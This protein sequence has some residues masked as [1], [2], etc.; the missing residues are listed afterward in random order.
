[1]IENDQVRL[2]CLI[3]SNP[4]CSQI[5]WLFNQDELS[6]RTCSN[7]YSEEYLIENIT[8]LQSGL[9]TCEVWN[10]LNEHIQGIS[11]SSVEVRVQC[12]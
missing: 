4:K 3:D 6:K 12:K 7:F 1:M 5:R 10:Q 2:R 11:S 9:Y 8:R